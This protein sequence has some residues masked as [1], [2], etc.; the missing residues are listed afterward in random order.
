MVELFF[1]GYFSILFL[2]YVVM[3]IKESK[4]NKHNSAKIKDLRISKKK[5][6]VN[7][8]QWCETNHSIPKYR[9][10]L[11]YKI[12]YYKHSKLEGSYCGY[13]KNIT[14]YITP[15]KRIIDVVD[16][17]LHEY[18]HHIEMRTQKEV[19]LYSKQL[20]Y[21][22]YDD[23]PMEISARKFAKQYRDKCFETFNNIW[24]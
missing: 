3:T 22:G 18:Q 13:T 11:S 12:N 15:E 5:M 8:L 10:K 2:I 4:E 19:R 7:V 14:I 9:G 21:F 16:T 23:H 1:I 17:L 24:F 6:V 20:N